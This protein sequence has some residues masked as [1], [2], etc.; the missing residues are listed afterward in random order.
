[1]AY[2]THTFVDCA[3]ADHLNTGSHPTYGQKIEGGG[4]GGGFGRGGSVDA[5][6]SCPNLF[7]PAQS[8]FFNFLEDHSEYYNQANQSTVPN[9]IQY[10]FSTTSYPRSGYTYGPP[11]P[12][13]SP[14]PVGPVTSPSPPFGPPNE[15]L[16][17]GLPCSSDISCPCGPSCPSGLSCPYYPFC[18]CGLSCPSG[19]HCSCGI[20]CELFCSPT[21]VYNMDHQ[22]R[23]PL[24]NHPTSQDWSLP[25]WTEP[26]P[27]DTFNH[28][29]H[30]TL[31]GKSISH[32]RRC[33]GS[34]PT[35]IVKYFL[36]N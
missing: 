10:V 18:P 8:S 26:L 22:Y 21:N 16:S 27:Q 24:L 15:P 34:N 31:N 17:S 19:L 1:M 35:K 20:I 33:Y 28:Q 4:E 11:V 25:Y 7:Y 3:K 30:T 13:G 23:Q 29:P 12:T 32:W 5:Y 36:I 2:Q 14:S 9:Y 6:L